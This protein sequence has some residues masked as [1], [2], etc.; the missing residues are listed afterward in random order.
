GR[1]AS[2]P[3]GAGVR[4][5]VGNARAEMRAGLPRLFGREANVVRGQLVDAE[6]QV[7]EQRPV[8]RAVAEDAGVERAPFTTGSLTAGTALGEQPLA[9]GQIV[10]RRCR[11]G[12]G[13]VR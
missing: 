4:V 8:A 3:A 1:A 11:R 13:P 10:G 2:A 7:P 9:G 6:P 12:H 5:P